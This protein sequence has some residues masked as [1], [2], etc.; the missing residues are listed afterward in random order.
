MRMQCAAIASSPYP[1]P[2]AVLVAGVDQETC[3]G[4]QDH[5][6]F[7]SMKFF[8]K[9]A[10]WTM[11]CAAIVTYQSQ[12]QRGRVIVLLLGMRESQALYA[13]AAVLN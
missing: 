12:F 1:T 2:K 13:H 11:A 6:K 9:S 7:V 3:L 8:I 10:L 4:D 5:A